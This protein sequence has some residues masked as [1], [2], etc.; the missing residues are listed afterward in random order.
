MIRIIWNSDMVMRG[1]HVICIVWY[2]LIKVRMN[3]IHSRWWNGCQEAAVVRGHME[4][5]NSG[6][7]QLM[8][9]LDL[10]H[11]PPTNQ[12]F[13]DNNRLISLKNCLQPLLPLESDSPHWIVGH[14]FGQLW[15]FC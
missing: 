11:Y 5:F 13:K 6:S 15:W 10:H 3:T 14:L 8:P 1:N 12:R 4:T 9:A 2:E 7:T